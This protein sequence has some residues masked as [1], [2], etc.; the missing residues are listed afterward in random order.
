VLL[1]IEQ[2]SVLPNVF[3]TTRG[4]VMIS[5]EISALENCRVFRCQCLGPIRPIAGR[6]VFP[7]EIANVAQEKQ[8]LAE[9]AVYRTLSVRT[10]D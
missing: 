6:N 7:E 8:Y 4:Q 5:M 3:G 10:L 1:P 9:C 2:K